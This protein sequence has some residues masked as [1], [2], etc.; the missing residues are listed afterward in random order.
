MKIHIYS[1]LGTALLLTLG[2]LQRGRGDLCRVS[3]PVQELVDTQDSVFR[4]ALRLLE[5]SVVAIVKMLILSGKGAPRVYFTM[6]PE[7]Y[8]A[9]PGTW[10][11]AYVPLFCYFV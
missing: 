7:N 2:R 4:R 8:V 6:F 3:F 10:F 5:W 11:E 1:T 9:S